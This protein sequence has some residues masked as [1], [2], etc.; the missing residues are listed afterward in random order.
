M[1]NGNGG[2]GALILILYFVAFLFTFILIG[3]PF[4]VGIRI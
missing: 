4:L 2:R 3:L 1:I